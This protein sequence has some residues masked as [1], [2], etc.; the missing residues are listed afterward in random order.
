MQIEIFTRSFKVLKVDA[1]II[2]HP[3][4][5]SIKIGIHRTSN[6]PDTWSA[7]DISTGRAFVY[8][9]KTKAQC[10]KITN[11]LLKERG[12]DAYKKCIKKYPTVEVLKMQIMY[13]KKG[14]SNE[15]KIQ[16]K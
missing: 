10:V 15:D 8:G 7:S 16:S 11:N 14:G 4:D 3:L 9:I 13:G 12:M 1:F 2:E 5:S 6:D